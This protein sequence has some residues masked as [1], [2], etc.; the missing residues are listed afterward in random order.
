[1]ASIFIKTSQLFFGESCLMSAFTKQ[2][3]GKLRMI[4]IDPR[5]RTGAERGHPLIRLSHPS[6]K[7]MLPKLTINKGKRRRFVRSFNKKKSE[8][9][10]EN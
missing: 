6:K 5:W 9:F 4:E 7:S 1:M 10:D 2:F 3:F 8:S